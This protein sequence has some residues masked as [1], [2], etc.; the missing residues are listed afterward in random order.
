[1]I[2]IKIQ[3]YPKISKTFPTSIVPTKFH[4]PQNVDVYFGCQ[5]PLALL[6]L[7]FKA[8]SGEKEEVLQLYNYPEI[9]HLAHFNTW[10][11]LLKSFN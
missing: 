2:L 4:N 1:M 6:G 10:M 5:R 9:N 11:A 3:I 8:L 7:L